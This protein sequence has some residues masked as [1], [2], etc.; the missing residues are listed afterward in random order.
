MPYEKQLIFIQPIKNNPSM[1]I[2]ARKI[3]WYEDELLRS[4]ANMPLPDVPEAT[5]EDVQKV[6]SGSDDS[7]RKV[8]LRPEFES[9][10]DSAKSHNTPLN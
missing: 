8:R 2:Y 4:R 10:F 6:L 5:I 1:Q 7:I 3:M 9:A